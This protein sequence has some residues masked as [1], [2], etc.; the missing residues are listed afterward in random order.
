[1][2]YA[3]AAVA[4]DMGAEVTLISGPVA[5]QPVPGCRMVNVITTA[6]MLAAV[7]KEYN[8]HDMLIMAAAVADFQPVQSGGDKIPRASRPSS[9]DLQST[10]DILKAIRKRFTGTLVAFSLQA[11]S[12]LVPARKKLKDKGA[13]FIVV[14]RYD[15]PGAG[16]E[17]DQNHV[18]VLSASGDEVEIP[19]GTK[20]AV[21]KR[22]LEEILRGST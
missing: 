22:I 21:A 5:L 7:E 18:W 17:A 10:P 6:E 11:G 8:I 14:N 12:D 3:L 1:M 16:P 4:R 9:L 20:Q 19:L 2:G 13:E 15:E